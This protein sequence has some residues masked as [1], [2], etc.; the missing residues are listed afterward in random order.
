[1]GYRSQVAIAIKTKIY[2]KHENELREAMKDCDA[3][4]KTEIAYVIS[5]EYVK[6]YDSYPSVSSIEA[7]LAK[8]DEEDYGY[9]RIGED[10]GDVEEKGSPW[11]FDIQINR[12]IAGLDDGEDLEPITFFAPNSVKFIKED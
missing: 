4:L 2:H 11:D 1:M 6:W 10:S 5:W 8:L 3:L 12:C 7:V 9:L